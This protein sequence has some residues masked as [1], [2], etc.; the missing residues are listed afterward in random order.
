MKHL[1]LFVVL[2]AGCAPKLTE[3]EAEKLISG[4]DLFMLSTCYTKNFPRLNLGDLSVRRVKLSKECADEVIATGLV[5]ENGD[6]SPGA[7]AHGGIIEGFCGTTRRH[8]T[9]VIQTG[10]DAKVEYEVLSVPPKKTDCFTNIFSPEDH[11]GV[12]SKELTYEG[13]SWR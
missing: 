12:R 1:I 8:V 6:V 11:G 9:K 2:L 5:D 10:K 7:L 3:A 4:T 13:R